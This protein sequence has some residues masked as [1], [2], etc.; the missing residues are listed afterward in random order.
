M[1]DGWARLLDGWGSL[2]AGR[3]VLLGRG[4]GWIKRVD[5]ECG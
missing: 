4:G 3:G 1:L 2:K 5:Q